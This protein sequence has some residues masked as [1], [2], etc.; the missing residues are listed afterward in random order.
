MNFVI[1]DNGIV[2]SGSYTI[3]P[4]Y[5]GKDDRDTYYK[6]DENAVTTL[7]K[8]TFTGLWKSMKSMIA[9]CLHVET[10]IPTKI[11][12]LFIKVDM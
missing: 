1:T 3:T 10:T 6:E 7:T 5:A 2:G 9:Y 12:W 4:G 11:P 8:S